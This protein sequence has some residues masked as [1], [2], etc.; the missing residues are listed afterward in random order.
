MYLAT[1]ERSWRQL[2]RDDS[3]GNC[4]RRGKGTRSTALVVWRLQDPDDVGRRLVED[5]GKSLFCMT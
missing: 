4:G 2:A 5:S 3:G 1:L